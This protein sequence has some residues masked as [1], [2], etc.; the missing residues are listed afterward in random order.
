MYQVRF[1]KGAVRDLEKLDTETARRIVRKINWLAENAETIQLKGL[2]SNLS[3][4]SKLREGDYRIIY[5]LIHSEEL[6]IIHFI[7][8]RREVYKNK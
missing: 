5:E 7:G 3:G 8:H 1:I 6:V 2:R 4:L